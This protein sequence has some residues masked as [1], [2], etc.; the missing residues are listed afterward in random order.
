M[1]KI[2]KKQSCRT[3]KI[4]KPQNLKK[5]KISKRQRCSKAIANEILK[6]DGRS[7]MEDF[8]LALH[9]FGGVYKVDLEKYD[10]HA[11]Q[12]QHHQN[13]QLEEM[14]VQEE[15]QN[16]QFEEIEFQEEEQHPQQQLQS[17]QLGSAAHPQ[18][19]LQNDQH[20]CNE[21]QEQE[22]LLQSEM[23]G[24][25]ELQKHS[26]QYVAM[27]QKARKKN[28]KGSSKIL[29]PELSNF[30]RKVIF[31][32]FSETEVEKLKEGGLF[33]RLEQKFCIAILLKFYGK[34]YHL[35]YKI[36]IYPEQNEISRL[37]TLFHVADN[38]VRLWFTRQRYAARKEKK[39]L[40]GNYFYI[41]S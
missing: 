40:Q 3:E 17:V 22:Q 1:A 37:A 28:R 30:K 39:M 26:K 14:E 18:Q 5:G 6:R 36:N 2:N 9:G 15:P 41:Q 7:A 19:Q 34:F 24:G 35:A 11:E 4:G 23:L 38:K 10:I 33:S 27:E 20:G 21:F 31:R 8:I 25:A 29:G 13:E 32:K 16:A 12:Q